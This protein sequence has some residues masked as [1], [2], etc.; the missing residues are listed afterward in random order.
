MRKK[1]A[2]V[3]QSSTAP[4]APAEGSVTTAPA[5]SA[6]DGREDEPQPEDASSGTEANGTRPDDGG[7]SDTEEAQQRK[8][9]LFAAKG[10]FSAKHR[11]HVKDVD[12][13]EAYCDY[14]LNFLSSENRLRIFCTYI[15]HHP[16]FD[17]I[18]MLLI[19]F[20]SVL[21]ALEDFTVAEQADGTLAQTSSARNDLL[22]QCEYPLLAI[23][24]AEAM[25]KIVAMG[26]VAKRNCYLRDPWNVLDFIVVLAGAFPQVKALRTV[27]VLRPLRTLSRFPGMRALV[28]ALL[29][30]LPPLANLHNT[31]PLPLSLLLSL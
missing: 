12:L 23:F 3:P 2:V 8:P 13:S 17:Q 1:D 4:S 14:S 27:R 20:S 6:V 19:I 18:I 7:Q 31:L 15:C 25:C 24:A 11:K 21:L 29:N 9:S 5:E 26:F 30:S 10:R 22:K 16:C 28:A